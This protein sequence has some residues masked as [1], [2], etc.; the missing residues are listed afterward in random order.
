MLKSEQS[1]YYLMVGLK[2]PNATVECVGPDSPPPF[3]S[4][5]LIL[6]QTDPTEL[7]ETGRYALQL[8]RGFFE[9]WGH[10]QDETHRSRVQELTGISPKFK[11]FDHVAEPQTNRRYAGDWMLPKTRYYS[12][13]PSEDG[14]DGGTM[15]RELLNYHEPLT[16]GWIEIN[17][18]AEKKLSDVFEAIDEIRHAYLISIPPLTKSEYP[19]LREVGAPQDMLNI[20]MPTKVERRSF[21]RLIDLRIPSVAAWFTRNLT[22]LRWSSGTEMRAFA[23]KGPLDDFHELLPSL[24]VQTLGGGECAT[25]IAGQWLRVLGADALVFPSARSDAFVEVVDGN[26]V[27]WGGWNLV[28]YTGAPPVRVWSTDMTSEWLQYFALEVNQP[29]SPLYRAVRIEATQ[30]GPRAGSWAV[31]NLEQFRAAFRM[32]QTAMYLYKWAMGGLSDPQQ[33]LLMRVLLADGTPKG[34]WANSRAVFQAFLGDT[35][36]RSS[37]IASVERADP[38]VARLLVFEEAFERMDSRMNSM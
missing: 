19:G 16:H 38:T 14:R 29:L 9:R 18:L 31:K 10:G 22:R 28:D 24:L 35:N 1:P 11:E 23:M 12:L 8:F 37:V 4:D 30:D 20:I 21:E 33:G 27:G 2:D 7:D 6:K 25:R 15:E 32:S 17:D 26:V 5:E 3:R 36:L 13:C 34:V